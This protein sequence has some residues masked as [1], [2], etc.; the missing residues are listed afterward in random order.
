MQ[1]LSTGAPTRFPELRHRGRTSR[2]PS[3]GLPCQVVFPV[4]TTSSPFTSTPLPA[5]PALSAPAVPES[6]VPPR[7]AVPEFAPIRGS[8]R[9]GALRAA[10]RRRHKAM[11]AGLAVV[12]MALALAAAHDRPPG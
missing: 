4:L 6:Y 11:A 12:A 10:L 9:R 1:E 8:G 3:A 5:G 7:V 2:Y